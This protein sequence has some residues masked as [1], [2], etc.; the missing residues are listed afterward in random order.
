MFSWDTF[1]SSRTTTTMMIIIVCSPTSMVAPTHQPVTDGHCGSP[2]SYFLTLNWSEMY[3]WRSWRELFGGSWNR[4]WGHPGLVR[5]KGPRVREG[6]RG[7]VCLR[8]TM[9]VYIILSVFSAFCEG[10]RWG[11]FTPQWVFRLPAVTSCYLFPPFLFSSLPLSSP[12]FI[13]SFAIACISL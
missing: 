9:C 3:S 1:V 4:Q 5:Q 2:T 6:Y 7:S 10:T 8:D 13:F 12:L 11:P